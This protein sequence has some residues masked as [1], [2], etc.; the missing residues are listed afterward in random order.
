MVNV[1]GSADRVQRRHRVL[2]VPI[3]VLYKF[4]DDQGN[5][6]AATLT[7]YAFIAIFPLLLLA[8]SIFGFVLQGNPELQDDV[9]NSAL[10]QFPIIGDQL[11]RPEGLQGSTTAVV[12]GALAALYGCLGLGLAIQNVMATAWG[13]PRN[14]RPNPFLLRFK[15]LALLACAAVAVLGLSVLGAAGSNTAVIGTDI[16]GAVRWAIVLG[17]VVVV[18]LVLTALFRLAAARSHHLGR[19]APGAFFVA[20]L[21]QGLQSLG[22][23]YATNVLSGTS[24]MNKTFGLVLGL[25]GLIYIASVIGVLGVEVNVVLARRLWPRALLTPFTD[26]V[27]LTEADRRAYAMYAQMQ[28]HKG[29]ETVTVRFDGRDG[30]T[31]EIVLDGHEKEAGTRPPPTSRLVDEPG[32]QG[33]EGV[34]SKA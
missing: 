11:G 13:V 9:L 3:A 17:T 14:S 26:A 15:S 32:A 4:F 31:Y 33:G 22:S 29:F 19:A 21:W 7:Y 12:V 28:R 20:L 6:L 24:S 8:S 2:G 18:G 27:D 10:S 16:H 25:V 34:G 1:V 5:Y 30:D 23:V